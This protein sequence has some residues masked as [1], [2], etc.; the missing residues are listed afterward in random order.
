VRVLAGDLDGDGRD[1][2]VAA[3]RSPGGIEIWSGISP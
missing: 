2:L 1:E 3:T